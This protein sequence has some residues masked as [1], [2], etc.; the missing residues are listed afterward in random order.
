MFQG[1][2]MRA[3]RS[4]DQ[5]VA[6]YMGR[7]MVAVPLLVAGGFATAALTVKLVELYGSV[8]AYGVMAALFGVIGLFTMA[9]VNVGPNH[10][11]EAPAADAETAASAEQPQE[12]STDAGDFLT[13]E[14]RALFA[15]AAPMAL[16]P[17][18]RGI[19]KN[20]PLILFL[21]LVG[22][23]IS[24]FAEGSENAAEQPAGGPSDTPDINPAEVAA[25]SAAAA[26]A[27][28]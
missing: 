11:A 14:L 1:L 15:S 12:A 23:I 3:E 6:K 5:V 26:A 18:V 7:A 9:I 24:R 17:V 8:P 22:F 20:L 2:L 4:I 25:A 10:V 16:P 21:A 27:A 19:G 13:P 28:A